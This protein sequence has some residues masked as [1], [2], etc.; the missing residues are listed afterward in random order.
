SGNE[1]VACGDDGKVHA[2]RGADGSLLWST[3]TKMTCFMPSIADLDGDGK[4]EVVVEGG[5]LDGVTGALK[6]PF[7]PPVN[8][9]FVVSDIDGD[10]KLDVVTSSRGYDHLGN[11]FVDTGMAE[12]A[13]FPD[14]SDWKGPWSAVADFDG[15]GK[16]EV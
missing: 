13:D 4:P 2:F 6:H 16:P 8:G 12:D 11:M 9:P 7:T 14:T 10:G 3:E 5:I 1:V 15:D